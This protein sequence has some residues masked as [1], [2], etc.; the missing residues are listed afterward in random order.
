MQTLIV[1]GW[2]GSGPLHWQTWWLATDPEARLV[3]QADWDHPSLDAWVATAA[4]AV[5]A[6]PG[7]ILVGHSLGAALIVHLA[8]R[9]P[10]LPI[11]GALLVSPADVDDLTWTSAELASFAP[12]P[13]RQLAFPSIV[14][15]SR[16]DPYLDFDR[17]LALAG[18]WGSEL[19][20]VGE[21]GHV[22]ADSGFGAWPDGKRLARRLLDRAA[23]EDRHASPL[24][25]E[26]PFADRPLTRRR[27]APAR[28]LDRVG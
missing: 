25:P 2:Y 18:S 26:W 13:T 7:S 16:N 1:P 21:A 15:A 19:V 24:K 22:N 23:S 12:L 9:L 4:R 28:H 20:D 8:T 14:V 10:Q 3:K 6:A 27:M 5:A 11:G 17:A